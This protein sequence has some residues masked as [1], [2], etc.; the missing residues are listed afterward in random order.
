MKL[1][2]GH[3]QELTR[4]E[5]LSAEKSSEQ[6]ASQAE[7]ELLKRAVFFFGGIGLMVLLMLA[8]ETAGDLQNHGRLSETSPGLA[9]TADVAHRVLNS[10]S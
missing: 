8:A 2:I 5:S 3:P 9:K 1:Q 4:P 10:E 7:I 6:L